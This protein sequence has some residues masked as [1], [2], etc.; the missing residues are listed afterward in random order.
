MNRKKVLLLFGGESSEH[1]VSISSARNVFAALD[2]QKYEVICGYIDREGK[3]WLVN[4]LT[5]HTRE[6]K[7]IMPVLGSGHFLKLED[8]TNIQPDVILPILHGKNGED[9]SIAALGE[10]L[11]IPVVGCDMTSAAVCMDKVHTKEIA[12]K[13]AIPVVPY[14]VVRNGGEAPK[15]RAVTEEL[16]DIL[17]IKPARSGSSV[18][19]S[20][21]T[22]E[23]QYI[24]AIADAHLH[25][26][27]ALIEAAIDA[28]EIELSVLGT[29]PHHKVSTPGEIIPDS[30]FYTYQSKYSSQSASKSSIPAD[31]TDEQAYTLQQYAL[32]A[33]EVLGC[34]GLARVDFFLAGDTIYLNEI[35]TMPGF[36]D[37]SMYPKL[38]QHGGL[39]NAQLIDELI[40]NALV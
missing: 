8:N 16:G 28:R 21:V 4:D 22:D 18:G 2:S 15:F 10:L 27:V 12:M 30:E 14:V 9:G 36:T 25:G 5:G 40:A 17:F 26:D 37:I 34:S 33:F 38:W 24:T 39:S 20:K 35:N 7:H 6:S 11:H 19:V 29:P 23:E 32:T 13:H 3:W 1:D 31:I